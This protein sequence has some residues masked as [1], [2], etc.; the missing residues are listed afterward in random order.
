MNKYISLP[1]LIG[2]AFST[3][4]NI[5]SDYTTIQAGINASVDGDTVL[6]AQGTY[7]ENL[8][9]ANEIVLAS[10]AIYDDLESDW[11]DN[12]NILGTIISGDH[13]GSCLIIRDGNIEPTIIGLTFQ[14][15]IGTSIL[16]MVCGTQHQKRSG[17]AILI[18]KAYPIINYN[19]FINNGFYT[20]FGVGG[21]GVAE[22]GAISHFSDDDIEFDE[23]RVNNSSQ[24][25][26]SSRDIPEE[27]NI[28][29]NYFEN[30]SSGNGQNFYSNGYAGSIDVSHSIFEDI[31]CDANSVNEYVLKSID[32][33]ADYVQ[34]DISGNCIEGNSFYVSIY[35]DDNN[36]GIETD[37]FL[38]I[39]HAL[40][41]VR[42]LDEI[43]TTIYVRDG[44]YSPSTNGEIFP[45]VL[46]DN[47]HLI[48]DNRENSI[49]DAEADIVK[50]SR[51]IIIDHGD[52]IKIESLTITGGYH[53][54]ALCVG[55]G[56]VLIGSP[57]G[58]FSS[59]TPVLEN[60]IVSNNHAGKGGGIFTGI[61]TNTQIKN[62]IISNNSIDGYVEPLGA[63]IAF[64]IADG[65]LDKVLVSGNSSTAPNSF[66]ISTH[67]SNLILNKTTITQN[68][69]S[70]GF[71]GFSAQEP[72]EFVT[73]FINSLI[74]GNN[75]TDLRMYDMAGNYA[76]GN[77]FYSAVG[78]T[79]GNV[80]YGEGSFAI[81]DNMIVAD[82]DGFTLLPNSV[83]IDAGTAD[84]NNDGIEDIT[85]YS[86]SA[87]DIGAFESNIPAP[88]GFQYILQSSSVM[89]WWDPSTDENFQY[90]LLE[91]STDSLFVEN[92]VSN[93]LVGSIY[94]DEDLEFNTLY[95]YR[96]SYFSTGWSEYSEIVFVILEDLDISNGDN[97]PISYKIHQN[98]PN[99]FNPMT[100]IRYDLPEDGLV[101][102]TIYDM[103]GRVVSN[104]VSTQQTAGY[105]S[106]QWNAT[107]NL[108]QPVAAGLYLYTIQTGEFRQTKKMI[109][110]K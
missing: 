30:N 91:R 52:N 38:T 6:V 101:N 94:T 48:G 23:D 53:T 46:P 93:Y 88:T 65:T 41:L 27:M 110:L 22:G 54:T 100:T 40:T 77:L 86:G 18:Y 80:E 15:G 17:G 16:E 75:G 74:H 25:N 106:I 108:G 99:P 35:G 83:C 7:S 57:H 68:I 2:L 33:E 9:L 36:I 107:N 87:P 63:G 49:V 72:G 34:N 21:G 8:I 98:H 5:P 19:R 76:L 95:F 59:A 61:G 12:E 56:G 14:D 20:D 50:Q 97:M 82:D 89:L 32:D 84:L 67:S 66:G 13:N 90:F 103:M 29:N 37:P 31:D 78:T 85:D 28:Q 81:T 44:V 58:D 70:G 73:T 1:L 3:T 26:H 105:K 60:L 104:L 79:S 55:G 69:G 24:N 45:I 39:G 4:I 62:S 51:V 64:W 92:V 10:H 71:C 109:L 42:D 43:T 96:V 11:L 47:V 102:I